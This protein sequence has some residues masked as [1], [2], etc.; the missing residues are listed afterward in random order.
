MPSSGWLE[1]WFN[2]CVGTQK[3]GSA[4]IYGL[5]PLLM[6]AAPFGVVDVAVVAGVVLSFLLLARNKVF[7][8][9]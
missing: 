6:L 1:A 8:H 9:P 7:V 2:D 3:G 5:K 4:G